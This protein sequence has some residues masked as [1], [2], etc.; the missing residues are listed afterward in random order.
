MAS[1]VR[2]ALPVSRCVQ[3]RG[4]VRTRAARSSGTPRP[5]PAM[6]S[7]R[8][9]GDVVQNI[10]KARNAQR[11]RVNAASE[12][13]LRLDDSSGGGKG[14]GKTPPRKKTGEGE[15]EGEEEGEKLKWFYDGA[16]WWIQAFNIFAAGLLV[17]K[18]LQASYFCMRYAINGFKLNQIG[19]GGWYNKARV[20]LGRGVV[21]SLEF[22]LISDILETV[23]FGADQ[24]RLINIALTAVVRTLIDYFTS[25]EI[26]E[27]VEELEKIEHKKHKKGVAAK[28]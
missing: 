6:G 18:G 16:E 27:A 2:C 25:K 17:F 1:L 24:K 5:R 13:A 4:S 22:L 12:A 14:G 23:V 19:D 26:E 21:L 15:G 10:F 7:A 3:A 8:L 9:W 11:T 28:V 20:V